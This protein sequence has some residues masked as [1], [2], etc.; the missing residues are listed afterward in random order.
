VELLDKRLRENF[1]A[2]H[3]RTSLTGTPFEGHF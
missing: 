3:F 1:D 2:E